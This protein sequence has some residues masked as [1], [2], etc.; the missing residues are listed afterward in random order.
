MKHLT[1]IGPAKNSF[2]KGRI[3]HTH[4]GTLDIFDD[5]IDD[6]VK[7]HVDMFFCGKI[8]DL[9]TGPNVET[10]H[11]GVG[12]RSQRNIRLG[13]GSGGG[14]DHVDIDF[15]IGLLCQRVSERLDGSVHIGFYNQVQIF[16]LSGF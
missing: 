13:N 6:V 14:M 7:P 5:F 4:N 8:D 1:H 16:C 11:N 12:Y 15:L 2:F 9:L 10:D 3:H